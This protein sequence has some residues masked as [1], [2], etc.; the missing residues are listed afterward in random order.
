MIDH[1]DAFYMWD[2]EATILAKESGCH[3]YALKSCIR[4]PLPRVVF[5]VQRLFLG[6]HSR[7]PKPLSQESTY[8]SK[9]VKDTYIYSAK[10]SAHGHF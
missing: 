10:P 8:L 5:V 9:G 3:V 4:K 2:Q 1:Q 6:Q 7:Q